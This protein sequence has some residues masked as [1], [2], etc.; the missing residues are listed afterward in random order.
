MVYTSDLTGYAAEMLE[1]KDKELG[2]EDNLYVDRV[3]QPVVLYYTDGPFKI[4]DY[5]PYKGRLPLKMYDK[6]IIILSKKGRFTDDTS[7]YGKS[8]EIVGENEDYILFYYESDLSD[9]KER[10]QEINKELKE[11]SKNIE[12]NYYNINLLEQEKEALVEKIS[13]FEEI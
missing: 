7:I 2:I 10:V 5:E 4:I 8:P 12:I 11:L 9:D 3:L 6:R 13:V 1:L